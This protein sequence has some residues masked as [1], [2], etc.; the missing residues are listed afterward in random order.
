MRRAVGLA[1]V[2]P[3]IVTLVRENAAPGPGTDE[4]N[5]LIHYRLSRQDQPWIYGNIEQ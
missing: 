3:I 5:L 2:Y 4:G 1:L